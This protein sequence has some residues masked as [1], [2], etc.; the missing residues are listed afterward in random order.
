MPVMVSLWPEGR[1]ANSGV[2]GLRGAGHTEIEKLVFVIQGAPYQAPGECIHAH[3]LLHL[4][5]MGL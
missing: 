2:S 1:A 3:V 4:N 5:P